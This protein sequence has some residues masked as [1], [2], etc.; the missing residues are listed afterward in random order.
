MQETWGS[1]EF[2][3]ITGIPL[4]TLQRWAEAGD[5]GFK[6]GHIWRFTEKDRKKALNRRG[7]L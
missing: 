3:E 2:A 6:I 7:V 4:R 5:I 1:K